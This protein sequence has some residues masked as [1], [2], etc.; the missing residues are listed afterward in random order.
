MAQI[1]IVFTVCAIPTIVSSMLFIRQIRV[2][3]LNQ[4]LDGIQ[5]IMEMHGQ[6]L[7]ERVKVSHAYLSNTLLNNEHGFNLRRLS[8]SESYALYAHIFWQD[9]KNQLTDNGTGADGYFFYLPEFDYANLA[10]QN[11]NINIKSKFKEY[12]STYHDTLV[13]TAWQKIE[14][15]QE[16]WLFHAV[17]VDNL[18]L[19]AAISADTLCRAVE[20][21]ILVENA[22]VSIE[23]EDEAADSKDG[24]ISISVPLERINLYMRV[25]V[26]ERVLMASLPSMNRLMLILMVLWMISMPV[27]VAIL[28]YVLLR[29]VQ[30]IKNAMG[31]IERGDI[32]YRITEDGENQDAQEL[33]QY[34]NNMADNLKELRIQ[35]YEKELERMDVEATN[36]RLQ[37]NP[38]FILNSLNVIFS[39]ARNNKLEN[40]DG[41]RVFTKYLANYLRFTLWNTTGTVALADEIRNVDNYME[42]QKIR[43]PGCFIYLCNVEEETLEA[44]IPSL[45][46]LNFVENAVKYALNME[47]EIEIVLTAVRRGEKL[48]I[49]IVDTGNG[50]DK[51][52][53]D[54]LVRGGPLENATGKHIGI[55]N[56]RRRMNLM[57]DDNAEFQI[58]SKPGEGTQ[59]FLE[60]PW[61]ERRETI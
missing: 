41:I 40:M 11:S 1:L 9:L 18:L 52:T 34:F 29:P 47:R 22:V 59:I 25:Q 17:E 26:D 23:S 51:E 43:F 19:G 38:H 33:I 28:S 58:T 61:E 56:C 53:V 4:R 42:L 24:W 50:M 16:T 15:G 37:V 54:A 20:K 44:R 55:W 5:H 32:E 14:L 45:L 2:Q 10:V 31:R 21:D 57:Y 36:L 49:T 27:L 60:I 7:D 46:I 13:G 35:V 3:Y 12:I 48:C 39:L 6:R 8:N 30:R